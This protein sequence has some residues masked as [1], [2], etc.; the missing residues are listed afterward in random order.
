MASEIPTRSKK[1]AN[2]VTR[3]LLTW[4]VA[5]D[6]THLCPP[7]GQPRDA[8]VTLS[9]GGMGTTSKQVYMANSLCYSSFFLI[10]IEII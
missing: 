3:D 9:T 5:A 4:T 8:R 2:P 1:N 10:V 7:R 6:L